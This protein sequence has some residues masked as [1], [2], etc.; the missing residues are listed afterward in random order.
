MSSA[1]MATMMCRPAA[2]GEKPTAMTMGAEK[3]ALVCKPAAMAEM[4][5]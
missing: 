2:G 4:M 3:T 5:K 1:K